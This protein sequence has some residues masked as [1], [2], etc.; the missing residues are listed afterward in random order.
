MN[1]QSAIDMLAAQLQTRHMDIEHR[2]RELAQQAG[3]N[4]EPPDKPDFGARAE[5]MLDDRIV[6]L[7]YDA[8]VAQIK[9]H[10]VL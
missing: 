10:P 3:I 7:A 4:F 6:T 9:A 1:R 8:A 2:M 5:A